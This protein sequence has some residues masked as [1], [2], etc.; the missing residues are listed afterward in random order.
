MQRQK[1][2]GWQNNLFGQSNKTAGTFEPMTLVQKFLRFCWIGQIGCFA[3]PSLF[4]FA[5]KPTVQSGLVL[6]YPIHQEPGGTFVRA[7]ESCLK[8]SAS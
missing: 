5:N 2:R 8:S 4:V 7:G 1:V 3:N 6:R